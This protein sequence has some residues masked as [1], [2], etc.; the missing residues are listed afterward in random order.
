M[1][2][3]WEQL[4]AARKRHRHPS[5]VRGRFETFPAIAPYQPARIVLGEMQEM[6]R[7]NEMQGSARSKLICCVFLSP[8]DR[9]G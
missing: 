6:L 5:R 9:H 7:S 8:Q 2:D 1:A 4:A 3:T